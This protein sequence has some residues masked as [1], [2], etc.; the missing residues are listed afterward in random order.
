MR[1]FGTLIRRFCS[2]GIEDVNHD[3]KFVRLPKC[4]KKMLRYEETRQKN[5]NK[6]KKR[7]MAKRD[8]I[9]AMTEVERGSYYLQKYLKKEQELANVNMALTG[10]LRV[11]IDLDFRSDVT[12]KSDLNSLVRQVS[13][14][15]SLIKSWPFPKTTCSLNL[16][17]CSYHSATLDDNHR[18]FMDRWIVHRH[19]DT[20]AQVYRNE[21]NE[22]RVVYLSPDSEN[23][24][25]EFSDDKVCNIA[26]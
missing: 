18:A 14:A 15:Y 7:K 26:T 10:K 13:M 12:S 3:N 23:V 6:L 11:C 1:R 9:V 16:S 21:L 20:F 22:G 24:L 17:L 25:T 5:I 4:K 19:A 8:A 2:I